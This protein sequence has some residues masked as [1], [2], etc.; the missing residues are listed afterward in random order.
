MG[1][2]AVMV[3]KAVFFVVSVSEKFERI[4]VEV[5]SKYSHNE[6]GNFSIFFGGDI[7]VLCKEM[8]MIRNLS[9]FVF[10]C[11]KLFLYWY[12]SMLYM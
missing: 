12:G 5:S 1:S 10:Y 9:E 3:K 11:P 2:E 6:G 8:I 4:V 7:L